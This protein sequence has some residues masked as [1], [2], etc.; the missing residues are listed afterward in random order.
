MEYKLS[1]KKPNTL[2]LLMLISYATVSAVLFGPGIPAIRDYFEVSNSLIQLTIITFLF[3]Y[4]IAQLFYGSLANFFGRKKTIYWGMAIGIIGSILCALSGYFYSFSLLVIGR[5]IAAL[6]SGVGVVLTFT[7]IN[8]YFHSHQAVKITAWV[9]IAFAISP[10]VSST[11]GGFLVAHLG[12]ESCFWFLSIYGFFILIFSINLPETS[13]TNDV[14]KIGGIYK[15]Y[16]DILSNRKLI[17]Y[18]IILGSTTSVLYIFASV[19]PI[20]VINILK[21]RP[22]IYGALNLTLTLGLIL[23]N[24]IVLN[25]SDKVNPIKLVR[26]GIFVLGIGVSSFC[27]FFLFG[28][29]NIYTIFLPGFVIF[30]GIALLYSSAATLATSGIADKAGA[31]AIMCFINVGLGCLGIITVSLLSFE[32]VIVIM[33]LSLFLSLATMLFGYIYSTKPS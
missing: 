12:W 28:E 15:S 19:A 29:I 16:R 17:F 11:V 8:D 14:L 6:G 4:A 21:I 30:L 24:A 25:I 1:V 26:I 9:A 23:G 20:I 33:P 7:I 5:F 31:S 10:G 32:S 18:S 3:S 2:I 27:I 22:D 13:T